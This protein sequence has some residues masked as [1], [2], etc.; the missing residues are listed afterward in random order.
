MKVHSTSLTNGLLMS[1]IYHTARVL[2]GAVS[3]LGS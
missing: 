3:L 2:L 1:A